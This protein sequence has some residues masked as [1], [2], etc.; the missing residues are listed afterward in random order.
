MKKPYCSNPIIVDIQSQYEKLRR[1][2]K[3]RSAAICAIKQS[4]A[5]E[6]QD[7]DDKLTVLIGLVFS[8]CKKRELTIDIANE[9]RREIRCAYLRFPPDDVENKRLAE[10]E[11][12]LSDKSL[13]GDETLYRY[14]ATYIP[15][16][17]K[18]DLFS[19]TIVNPKAE[20]V[21]ILGW[22]I[23]LYKA[24]D[25]VDEDGKHRQIVYVAVCPPNKTPASDLELQKIGFIPMMRRGEKQEYQ[26][27]IIL[28]SKKDELSY[29]LTRIGC[30]PN[31]TQ[32]VDQA[33]VNPLTAMPLFG[34]L[35]K[36]DP[37]PGFED[38]VC[39]LYKKFRK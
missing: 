12:F 37:W 32:P 33:A 15:G 7:D 19:H 36:D 13:Y 24:D 26:A 17:K 35:K 2:G 34:R 10:L 28:K 21:G 23:L 6:L 16:W 27:Q 5:L 11:I 9:T 38:Q 8:L 18:G 1:A 39:R 14:R 25:Y 22:S 20:S 30:F 29:D 3:S 4:Y 31:I